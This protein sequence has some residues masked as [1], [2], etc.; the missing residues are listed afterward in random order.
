MAPIDMCARIEEAVKGTWQGL[1][2]AMF[3]PVAEVYRVRHGEKYGRTSLID[4]IMQMFLC[5]HH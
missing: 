1:G 2:A 5:E 4:I 3:D